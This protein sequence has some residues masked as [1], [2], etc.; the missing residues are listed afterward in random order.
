[1]FFKYVLSVFLLFQFTLSVDVDLVVFNVTVLG[2]DGRPVTGLTEKDFHIYEDGREEKIKIFQPEDSPSTVGLVIDNSGSM[3][4]KRNDVVGA[5]VEF[6][7]ASHPQ[8]EMFI[9]N[10]NRRPWLALPP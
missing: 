5:A 4:S 3:T 1:M 2:D 9:V 6:V 10:F 7:A 8:D